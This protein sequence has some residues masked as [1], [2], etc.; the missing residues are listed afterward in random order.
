MSYPTKPY[1]MK[2]HRIVP[3]WS[4]M[5]ITALCTRSHEPST[6]VMFYS[7]LDLIHLLKWSYSSIANSTINCKTGNF[8]QHCPRDQRNTSTSCG[9]SHLFFTRLPMSSLALIRLDATDTDEETNQCNRRQKLDHPTFVKDS[10]ETAILKLFP[11]H[12]KKRT[13]PGCKVVGW[14]S[15]HCLLRN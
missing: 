1:D 11:P 10:D 8:Q 9:S 4:I 13:T 3:S 6:I 7:Y 5:H 14:R 2:W 15:W 12:Q